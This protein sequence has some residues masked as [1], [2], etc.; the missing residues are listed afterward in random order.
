MKKISATILLLALATPLSAETDY[1]RNNMIR[2]RDITGANVYT[3]NTDGNMT[4]DI[5]QSFDK[6]D[7]KWNN[8]GEIEDVVLDRDG[9]MIGVIAEV[10]GFLDIGDKHVFIEIEGGVKLVPVDDRNYS[11]VTGGLSKDQLME[12]EDLDEGFW[13]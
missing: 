13:D 7:D 8:I 9:Q 2:T 12:R 6:I 3:T 1:D 5:N 4:W 11:L 10:G